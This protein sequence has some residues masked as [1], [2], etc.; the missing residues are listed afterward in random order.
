M[1]S[2]PGTRLAKSIEKS[3]LK[4]EP[5][6]SA[7]PPTVG[8]NGEPLL[9]VMIVPSCHPFVKN[10]S[11]PSDFGAGTCQTK[12]PL[13]LCRTSKSQA[14]TRYDYRAAPKSNEDSRSGGLG[15]A[16]AEAIVKAYAGEIRCQSEVGIG[17][18]FTLILPSVQRSAD[19]QAVPEGVL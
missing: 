19:R 15:L 3:P 1:G 8:V 16:I 13:K 10:V 7:P 9:A 18:R 2:Q 11:M 17:S 4:P 14:P 6:G 5:R 12:L